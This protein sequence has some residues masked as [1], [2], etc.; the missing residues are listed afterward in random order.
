MDISE[1]LQ[2]YEDYGQ[3]VVSASYEYFE[4]N[5][6]KFMQL[7][8]PSEPLGQLADQL[9]PAVD[10]DNWYATCL[11]TVGSMAGSGRIDWP[12]DRRERV[13]L[14]RELLKRMADARIDWLDYCNHF[15]YAGSPLDLNVQ[16]L[17]EQ[18]FRPF[19]RDF[20]RVLGDAT[21]PATPTSSHGALAT[22]PLSI[23]IDPSRLSD[24]RTLKVTGHDLTR[25]VRLCEELN[26][27]WQVGA[28]YAVIMLTRAII[29]HVPPLFG[30]KSFAEVANNYAGSKSFKESMNHLERGA[31]SIADQHL[32]VQIRAV[33]S[34]PNATQVNFSQSLD[35]LLAEI[36]RRHK[37]TGP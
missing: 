5:L 8:E 19:H 4:N 14:Q 28:Y 16:K 2:D 24:L 7:L 34:L 37:S 33:E 9:L 25:L 35:L 27:C 3:D 18:L 6:K 20:A 23:F 12:P 29:D 36:I 31:R 26:A 21:R 1:A 22:A 10:F 30:C 11:Q 32:H 13:A 17:K 15:A